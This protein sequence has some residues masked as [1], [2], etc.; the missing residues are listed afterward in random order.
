[1]AGPKIAGRSRSSVWL[2]KDP[3]TEALGDLTGTIVGTI[4]DNDHLVGFGAGVL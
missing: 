1:M 4:I 2:A 3:H